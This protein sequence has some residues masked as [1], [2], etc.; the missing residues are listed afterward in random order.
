MQKN[1]RKRY[2]VLL[3][4]VVILFASA[5]LAIFFQRK[6]HLIGGGI[7][8][9][10]LFLLINAHVIVSIILL[11]LI[12]RQSIKLMIERR[13][14]VPGSA[15]KKN[16]LFAFIIFSVIPVVFVFFLAGKLITTSIDHWFDARLGTGLKKGLY[17]HEQNTKKERAA[18]TTWGNVVKSALLQA[19][20]EKVAT[21]ITQ[22]KQHHTPLASYKIYLW[23]NSLDAESC[24]GSIGDEARVWRKF[25]KINDRST[26]SLRVDFFKLLHQKDRAFDFYGSL[27]WAT[28]VKDQNLFLILVHRY[29]DHIR[30]PLIELQNSIEDYSQLRSIQSPISWSYLV[31]FLLITL[32]ILF[33]STWCAFY[34]ARGISE[35]IK[36]LL[37]AIRKVRKGDLNVQVTLQQS[38]DLLSLISGFNEMTRSLQHAYKNLE[39]HNKEMIT[40]LEH[41]KESVFFIN[42][43]GRIIS[44]NAAAK[45][46][47]EHY[48]N[49]TRFKNKKVN[50][51]GSYVKD[52]FFALV[53][54]LR[55]I[56]ADGGISLSRE[57]SFSYDGEAKTFRVYVTIVRN[58]V[59]GK[60]DI[61]SRQDNRLRQGVLVIVEDMSNLYKINKIKTWQEAAKQMAHE[62]KN[63]LTP[64]QLTTQRLERKLRKQENCDPVL[65][66]CTQTIL[67]QVKIIKGLVSHFSEFAKMPGT[68]IEPLDINKIIKKVGSLYQMSYPDIEFSYDLEKFL[69]TC[70]ADKKKMKRVIINLLDNSVRALQNEEIQFCAKAQSCIYEKKIK[71]KTSFKTVRNQIELLI[72][73]SGPGISRQVREKLFLPY[74]SS[75]KKNMGLGLAIV[76]D[77]VSQSGG[78]VKLLSSSRGATFQ[79]LLPV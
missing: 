46:L 9:T 2:V 34:L 36:E 50:F 35:P 29:P 66:E 78:S 15:F 64:I 77:I 44:F 56:S 12:I 13:K 53:R 17:F 63:P 49:I 79:I 68:V 76:H 26:K 71:I 40:M 65:M 4:S 20:R 47:V 60:N 45:K 8:R 24:L 37:L 7:N 1:V 52:L 59:L 54:E 3:L 69:P 25:R 67:H 73:D 6:Q 23:G 18:I 42:D 28:K 32:L 57:F 14:K 11:Y 58:T 16:L 21:T 30:Y 72:A 43:Y 31:A 27:Y 10:F 51:L 22:L 75:D 48:L 74:V 39:F 5:W 62:I 70:K 55:A 38:D 33:L 61:S 19:G 41:I